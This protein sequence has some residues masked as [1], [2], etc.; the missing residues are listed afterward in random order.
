MG[1]KLY[2][3]AINASRHTSG[4]KYDWHIVVGNN[5]SQADFGSLM[6]FQTEN[7]TIER[8]RADFLHLLSR[9]T[10]SIS[11]GG[12]NTMMDILLTNTPAL[13]V[14]FEG[15]SEQ[16]QLIRA[17]AFAEVNRLTVLREKNLNEM[18]LLTGIEHCEFGYQ[19]HSRSINMNGADRLAKFIKSVTHTKQQLNNNK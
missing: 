12:Y 1:E 11:Q 14:P 5:F 10:V 13:V 18:T 15:Q 3:T 17:M 7:L 9:C 8:N 4:K 16:E 6:E 2:R 19:P